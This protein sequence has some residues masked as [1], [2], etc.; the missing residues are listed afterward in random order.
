MS[1]SLI[2]AMKEIR[3]HLRDRSLATGAAYTLMG[4]VVILG[5]SLSEAAEAAAPAC[6][7]A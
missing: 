5:V 3:E 7:S 6:C 4:P 1:S 2:V